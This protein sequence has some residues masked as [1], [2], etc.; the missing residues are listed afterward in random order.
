MFLLAAPPE[1]ATLSPSL[2]GYEFDAFEF[3]NAW[4]ASQ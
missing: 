1:S 3:H 2:D 4:N